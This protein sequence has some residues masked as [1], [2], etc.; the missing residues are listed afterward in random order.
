MV[1]KCYLRVERI[2]DSRHLNTMNFYD[3]VNNFYV[4]LH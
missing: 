4:G 3:I 2:N 1:K